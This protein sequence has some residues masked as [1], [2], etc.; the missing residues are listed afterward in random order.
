VQSASALPV[1]AAGVA[2]QAHGARPPTTHS[3]PA[4]YPASHRKAGMP[5]KGLKCCRISRIART[6]STPPHYP[7]SHRKAG[8]PPKGLKCCRLSR[9]ARTHSTPAHY[10]ASH[11]KAGMPPKGLKCCRLSRIA[12]THSTPAHYPASHRKAG[13]SPKGPEALPALTD[14]AYG[15]TPSSRSIMDT[16][17]PKRLAS[18]LRMT[19]PS[20]Q[21]SPA[22]TRRALRG[23]GALGRLSCE[24]VPSQWA[25]L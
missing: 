16:P 13:M 7:A 8:M 5:P 22:S 23:G 18:G 19:G 6:H 10:P 20:W 2:A 15:A 25:Y 21:G 9:I 12:R 14:R 11:R 24:C 4:H 17:R 1:I 3:T